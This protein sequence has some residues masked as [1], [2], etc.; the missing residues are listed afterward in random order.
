MLLT[1]AVL[2]TFDPP[3]V[4]PGDLRVQGERI[5]ERGTGLRPQE[6]EEVLDVEGALVVPGFVNAHTH[7]YSALAR[8]MPG[9]AAPPRSFREI[10]ERVWWRVDRALDQ[11]TVALSGVV[12]AIEAALSG[13]TVLIDH[14]SS[15]SFIRGSLATLKRTIESV[16]LRSV[17]CYE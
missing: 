1:G 15:P 12:G 16:G 2:A 10:L 4:E 3:Q 5:V 9:P 14:H 17:L 13:T 11:E 8:G 7:L 6:G